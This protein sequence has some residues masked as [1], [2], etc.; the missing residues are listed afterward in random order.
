MAKVFL[1]PSTQVHNAYT[2]GSTEQV[3]MEDVV[4]VVA[5]LVRAQGHDVKVGTGSSW[6]EN[7]DQGNAFMGAHGYYYAIH[8]D[9]GGGDGTTAFY[10]PRSATGRDMAEKLYARVAPVSVGKDNTVKSR[11]DLGE[12]N[13]PASPAC[14][15][16]VEF[17][18]NATGAHDIRSRHSAYGHAIADGILDKVGRKP[19]EK[20]TVRLTCSKHSANRLEGYVLSGVTYPMAKVVVSYRRPGETLWRPWVTLNAN[21]AG[22]FSVG[23][24]GYRIGIYQYRAMSPA[25]TTLKYPIWRY[26]YVEVG[27]LR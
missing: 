20:P 2:G 27:I 25:S 10:H 14:L 22:G 18:D 4:E 6:S 19:V 7:V 11:G 3:E 23:T 16:E 13:G 1:S 9:A 24:R 5:P 12:L 8:S 21:A 17:H 26:G 15:I